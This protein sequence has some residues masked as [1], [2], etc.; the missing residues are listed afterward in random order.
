MVG[1]YTPARSDRVEDPEI[2][3]RRIE[4]TRQ[5]TAVMLTNLLFDPEIP[6]TNKRDALTLIEWLADV[7]GKSK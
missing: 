1:G 2:I 5:E 7:T 3:N 4:E 6:Q